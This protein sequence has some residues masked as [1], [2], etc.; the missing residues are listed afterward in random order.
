M[1]QNLCTRYFLGVMT[2]REPKW[3]PQ[4]PQLMRNRLGPG[5]LILVTT[6]T[7]LCTMGSS[8]YL[9]LQSCHL[10]IFKRMLELA[11]FFKFLSIHSFNIHKS[12]GMSQAHNSFLS[13][14]R[15]SLT[16]EGSCFIQTCPTSPVV[17]WWMLN[18]HLSHDLYV[19][20]FLWLISI[21]QHNGSECELGRDEQRRKVI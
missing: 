6:A 3:L 20:G 2:S 9:T 10:H 19:W 21:Y 5:L 17:W 1:P 7:F 14:S 16:R 13:T 4:V 12:R 11:H 8:F 15:Q 18:N